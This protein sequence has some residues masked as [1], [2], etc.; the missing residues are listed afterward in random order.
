MRLLIL[1]FLGYL[2]YRVVRKFI[3]QG[4]WQVGGSA[5]DAIDEM[6]QDPSCKTYIPMREALTRTID[7]KRYYFCSEE[8]AD[9]FEKEAL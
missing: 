8:C 5:S 6:V 7:G 9:K 3:G 4:K 2:L 1:V